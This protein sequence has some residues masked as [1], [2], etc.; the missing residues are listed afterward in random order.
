M[1]QSEGRLLV[2]VPTRSRPESV[3]RIVQAWDDTEAWARA[4]LLLVVDADDPRYTEYVTAYDA[5]RATRLRPGSGQQAQKF[6]MRV[7]PEWAPLV[8][9]LNMAARSYAANAWNGHVAYAFMGDDHMPRVMPFGRRWTDA[10]LDTLAEMGTGIVYGDDAFQGEAL[11]TQW[12][13]T[14]DIVKALGGM[15]PA[16]VEHLYCD[17]SVYALGR[18]AGCLRYLP[19][20]LI[21]H[22]HPAARKVAT[23]EQYKRV[24]SRDQYARDHQA[25]ITWLA[26]PDGRDADVA[27][28]KQLMAAQLTSE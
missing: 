15:V 19:E 23:D 10:Y 21:E 16:P 2:I 9:K 7:A 26:R 14:K 3:A 28:V 24:N 4:D 6:W 25:Y 22:M 20:V 8:P 27:K 1:R 17:N 13:M 5:V 18:E 11:P 12:A